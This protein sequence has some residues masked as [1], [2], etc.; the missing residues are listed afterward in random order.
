MDFSAATLW[1][2]IAGVLVAVELATGTFYLLMLACGAAAAALAAHAGLSASLQIVCAALVGG[3]ATAAWHLR[4]ARAPRSAPAASNPDVLLDI[5]GTLQVDAWQGD[6]TARVHYRGAAWSVRYAGPGT[7]A[8]GLHR[9]V[10]VHGSELSV[11]PA[12]PR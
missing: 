4:R 5:G 11:A 2:V 1:W 8:A 7:P 10:S 6:G 3:G 9:I 12:T